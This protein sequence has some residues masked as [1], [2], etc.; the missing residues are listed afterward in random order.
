[1]CAAIGAFA[2]SSFDRDGNAPA[3]TQPET[4]APIRSSQS[5]I[6]DVPSVTVTLP[7]TSAPLMFK[8]Y[9]CTIDCSG[10]EAGHDWAEEND[11]TDEDDCDGKSESFI[12]G[13][14]SYVEE[15]EE[16]DDDGSADD[17]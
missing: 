16:N 6:A 15:M 11:I 1:M 13:C 10:H 2:Y 7:P 14:L 5:F 4:A 17:E 9:P 8:G 12:E 3:V